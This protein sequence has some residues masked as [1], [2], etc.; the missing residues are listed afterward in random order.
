MNKIG[1][2]FDD[3]RALLG[4][5]PEA[6]AGQMAQARARQAKLAKPQGGL[7][8]LEELAVWLCGWRG[9]EKPLIIRPLVAV[10]A[11]NHGIAK[12]AGAAYPAEMTRKMADNFAK[13]FAAVSQICLIND[14]GLK[15]YDL[16]LDCP[17]EDISKDA[18]MDE[19]SC[20]ATMAFGM[21][22]VS[23]GTDLL[24]LGDMGNGNHIA[25]AAL[26]AVL[27]GGAPEDWLGAPAAGSASAAAWEQECALARRAVALH[28]PYCAPADSLEALRRLGGREIAALAGA[29]LAARMEKIPVIL[30]GFVVTL[31]AA[32]LHKA[33]PRALDHCLAG[34]VSAEP[35]HR[36]LLHLLDKKPLLDLGL[37]MGEGAGAALAAQLVKA[38]AL[39]HAQMAAFEAAEATVP[40]A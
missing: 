20:A 18:A 35:G 7:G 14:L 22:S 23:G 26:A 8:R 21:E 3:F 10:F 31:A 39:C 2:P 33:N 12:N 16:A 30:D 29:I 1:R 32:V 11:G 34:H 19:R 13:G 6:D 25:A 9:R 38:A 36:K 28:R 4:A 24:C 17:T 5:L 27:Y 15:L 40:E 37:H